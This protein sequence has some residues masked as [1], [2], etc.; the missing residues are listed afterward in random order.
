LREVIFVSRRAALLHQRRAVNEARTL[1]VAAKQRLGEVSQLGNL[2][3]PLAVEVE[4]SRL[5]KEIEG[6]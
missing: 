1:P 2:P 3:V 4:Y 6:Q 5:V